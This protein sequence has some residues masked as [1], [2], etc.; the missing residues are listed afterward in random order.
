M[1]GSLLDDWISQCMMDSMGGWSVVGQLD[2]INLS[3][4]RDPIDKSN[5]ASYDWAR[6]ELSLLL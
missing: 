4:E 2:G 5:L 6:I 3:W 1:N